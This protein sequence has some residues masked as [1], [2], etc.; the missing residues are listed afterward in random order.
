MLKSIMTDNY[1]ILDDYISQVINLTKSIILVNHIE[2]I[3][4]NKYINIYHPN[5]T[6]NL[7]DKTTWRYYKHIT[8][9]THQLD[10]PIFI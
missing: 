10:E 3:L 2:A 9:Y 1:Y 6:I 7:D 5:F 4:Y 8:G